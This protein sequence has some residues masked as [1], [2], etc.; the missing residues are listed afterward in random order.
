MREKKFDKNKSGGITLIALVVTI[1]VL[2]ILA[3]ISIQML[4]GDNG[5][6]QRAGQAKERTDEASMIEQI[7]IEILGSYQTDELDLDIDKLSTNL[8]KIG[9]TVTG[10][11]FP[12]TITLNGY[13]YIINSDGSIKN[14]IKVTKEDILKD[15]GKYYGKEVTNYKDNNNLTWQILYADKKNI[16]LIS[17]RY[18]GKNYVPKGRNNKEVNPYKTWTVYFKNIAEDN[19]SENRYKGSED[20]IGNQTLTA[21]NSDFFEKNP[22]NDSDSMKAVAYLMDTTIWNPLYKLD[23]AEYAI[24]S[25]TIELIFKSY[26]DIT[27][28]NYKARCKSDNSGYEISCDNGN[29]WKSYMEKENQE[30]YI[31]CSWLSSSSAY[32]WV[33][34]P[35][36]SSALLYVNPNGRITYGHYERSH[37]ACRPVVCIKSEFY[38]EENEKDG[39]TTYTLNK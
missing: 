31:D 5:I 15:P 17:K 16:Y 1:I 38:L 34:S 22:S 35:S 3:G 4:T 37:A 23:C 33:A 39:I 28:K 24:G 7:Q 30:E 27:K 9:A 25:P 8:K 10:D 13:S 29:T 6:L 12:L 14:V 11:E 21:L 32:Y 18:I 2:L 20:I 19:T 36:S 26:N